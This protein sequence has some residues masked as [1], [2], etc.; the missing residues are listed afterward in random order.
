MKNFIQPGDVLTITAA[1]DVVSGAGVLSGVLFGVATGDALTGADLSIATTGV[2]ELPKTSAQAWTVGQAIYF[3]PGTGLCTTAS[4][5]AGSVF[6]GVATAV[7]ANPSATGLVRL[8]GSAP[9]AVV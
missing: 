5:G 3:A 7:A 1:A 2:F 9:A 8:N 4:N 6:I